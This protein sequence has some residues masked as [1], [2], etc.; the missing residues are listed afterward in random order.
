MFRGMNKMKLKIFAASTLIMILLT[1]RAM[2]AFT[3]DSNSRIEF[4][5]LEAF[6]S[7]KVNTEK[8]SVFWR[9]TKMLKTGQHYGILNINDGILVFDSNGK[10]TGGFVTVDMKSIRVTDIPP[11]DV[12]PIRNI[13]N[14]LNSDFETDTYPQSKFEITAAGYIN[15]TTL[16]VLGNMTIKNI[17]K[18]ISTRVNLKE[19][20]NHK[21][22][23]TS[24]TLKRSEWGIGKNANWLEKKLVD[25]EFYLNIDLHMKMMSKKQK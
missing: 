12:E 14:H 24:L 11:D 9:G 20:D 21:V 23:S 22:F 6:D 13:T 4:T 1:A 2:P 8:S 16:N 17:T 15:D 3:D 7:V 25:E 18:N 10:L 5:G 19:K